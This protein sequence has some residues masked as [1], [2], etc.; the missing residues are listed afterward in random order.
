M[1]RRRLGVGR[2]G[3]QH[4]AVVFH[5]GAAARCGDD[6][7]IESVDR[8]PGV[9]IGAGLGLGLIVAAKVMDQRPTTADARRHHHF[10]AVTRQ[11]PDRGRIDLRSEHV[12]DAAGQ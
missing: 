11:H 7:G 4:E 12:I 1:S 9:D 5:G 3:A 6:D 2:I 10:D 8:G